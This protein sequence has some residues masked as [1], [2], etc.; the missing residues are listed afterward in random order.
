[1]NRTSPEIL[2]SPIEYLKGVGPHQG[3]AFYAK[4]LVLTQF[5]DLLELYP[6]RHI[7]KSHVASISEINAATEFIQVAGWL[8][9][10]Q[11]VGTGKSKRLVTTLKDATGTLQL[12]WFQG[13]NWMEKNLNPGFQIPGIWQ[14]RIL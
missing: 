13:I 3:N 12:V 2:A 10:L 11:I 14:S 9:S 8:G 6:Y 4:N 7:D 5:R 1:M